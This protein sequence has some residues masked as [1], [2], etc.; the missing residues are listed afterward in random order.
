MDH[1]HEIITAEG[2]KET[3]LFLN[4]DALSR[5]QEKIYDVYDLET[6]YSKTV[7]NHSWFV[8]LLISGTL[9]VTVF[10]SLIVSHIIE[11]Q[12]REVSVNIESF[13]DLN[14]KNILDLAS[15]VETDY[16]NALTDRV[17][18]EGRWS[19]EISTLETTAESERYKI[20]ALSLS[21]QETVKRIT[22]ID[23]ELENDIRK[24]NE[25]YTGQIQELDVKIAEYSKQLASFDSGRIEQAQEMQRIA[26]A[27][28]L[29]FQHEKE[30]LIA[31]YEEQLAVY[32]DMFAEAQQEGL[33]AQSG[34]LDEVVARYTAEIAT[35][36][37]I[38]RNE[39]VER[40]LEQILE[41]IIP[42]DM[43]PLTRET[44]E[45]F[46]PENEQPTLFIRMNEDY[47]KMQHLTQQAL[48]IPWK[49]NTPDYIRGMN[50][51]FFTSLRETGNEVSRLAER[52]EKQ[53]A[54]FEA[55]IEA[56]SGELA[57][58]TA[59]NQTLEVQIETL[60]GQ[61]S[62]FTAENQMLVNGL[63]ALN[64]QKAALE[65]QVKALSEQAAR[66]T[67]ENQMFGGGLQA[68]N[69][70]KAALEA[71]IKALSEQMDALNDLLARNRAYFGVLTEKNGVA[72]YIIDP[73]N[74][75]SILVYIDPLYGFSFRDRQ[76]HVFRTGNEYIGRIRISGDNNVFTASVVELSRGKTIEVGDRI[77][78]GAEGGF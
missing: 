5:I 22:A 49:N 47:D 18:I 19:V 57:H 14:L 23:G 75:R 31:R 35:L 38:L 4:K 3:A 68:L 58:F 30:E 76:A 41:Q 43:S 8:I 33:K 63:Q 29:R 13:E 28:S 64:E 51:L 10:V 7:K 53:K 9:I 73:R 72:G 36:D 32:R 50:V 61:V 37:P 70:Q 55:Q 44:P 74:T 17:A 25:R 20:H 78:L 54:A 1:G 34:S 15:R 2:K 67:T 60:S 42:L 24:V 59:E 45:T 66:L 6:E 65:V 11:N 56:L 39:E 12:T 27:E 69:E 77:L 52:M 48:T 21:S 71:Q 62:H 40:I 26:N 16:Q 46:A